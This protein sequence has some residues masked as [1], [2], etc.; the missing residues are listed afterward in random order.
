MIHA[1]AAQAKKVREAYA[2]TGSVNPAY[3]KAHSK[4]SD[5]RRANMA[6]QYRRAR[7][8]SPNAKTPYDS[9]TQAAH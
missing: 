8:L 3:E 7:G 2:T 5:M 4:L 9:T 6:D 1:E